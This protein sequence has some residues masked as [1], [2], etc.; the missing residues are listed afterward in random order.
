MRL[1][2][3]RGGAG[4]RVENTLAAFSNALE[5]GADGAELDVH[6]SRDGAVVVHHDAR[7]NGAYCRKPDGHWITRGEERPLAEL[8]YDEMRQ[9]EIGVPNPGRVY[10]RTFDRIEPV[11]DQRIPL[12]RDV[13]RLAKSRSERFFLVIEIKTPVLDAASRPWVALVDRTLAVIDAER[14][15][16]RA[17]LCSFDWG[18]LIYAEQCRPALATWFTTDPLSWFAPGRPPPTDIPPM[19]RELSAIRSAYRSGAPWFA[20]FDPRVD[21]GGVPAAISAAGGAAWLM[22]ASDFT[23]ERKRALA[24]RGLDAVV[25]TAN[26]RDPEAVRR[27]FRMGATNLML[28]YPDIDLTQAARHGVA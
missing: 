1:I 23:P 10:A 4:L 8:T 9:F 22:Y 26:L 14:F 3:H 6:L 20:G 15:G 28:D 17:V 25:W 7:L 5:L 21:A 19:S 12:L 24:E 27:L 2:A 16:S 18:A 11:R 13:I